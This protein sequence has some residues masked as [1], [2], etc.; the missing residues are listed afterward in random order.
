MTALRVTF[1]R[2]ARAEFVEA[3]AWYERQ[4]SGLGARFIAEIEQ[5]VALAAE[6]PELGAIV[7]NNIRRIPAH[8][9]PYSLYFQ[10]ETRR[11]VVVAVFHGSRDPMIWH[12][13]QSPQ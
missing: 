12:R 10:V 1:H 6:R 13:R 9:F 11:I 5:C 8:R 3:A 7:Y 2:A 4:H